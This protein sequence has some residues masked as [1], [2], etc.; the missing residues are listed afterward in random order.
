MFAARNGNPQAVKVLVEA[1]A[2]VNAR[3][4]LRGTTALMWAAEQRHPEAVK[5]LLAAGADVGAKSAGAGLPRNYMANRVNLRAVSISPGAPASARRAAG[6]TYEEQLALEQ[7]QGRELGGQRGLAQALGPDGL[8]LRGT[9]RCA[10]RQR[11][12]APAAAA[13]AG[14]RRLRPVAA[15]APGRRTR[16]PPDDDD[17]NE[18]VFAGLVG[19]GGGGLT[20]ARL[21]RARGRHRI[22]AGAARRRRQRQPARPS[23]AGRRC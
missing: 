17:D 12:G 5:V 9:R 8:P 22:G 16:R 7:K 15:V 11:R 1:G 18:V 19:S 20:R 4:R 10:G 21:R 2:D 13:C 14:R 23:T 3:E 6:I